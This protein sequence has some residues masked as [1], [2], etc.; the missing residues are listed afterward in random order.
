MKTK[1]VIILLAIL[2]LTL[3]LACQNFKTPKIPEP[4]KVLE[5]VN[6]E[7]DAIDK[8]IKQINEEPYSEDTNSFEKDLQDIES[9][10]LE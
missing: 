10:P 7:T 9:F 2:T 1:K 8:S 3:I 5:P 6:S 4:R